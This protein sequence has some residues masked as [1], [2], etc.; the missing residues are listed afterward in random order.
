MLRLR[1]VE[2][3]AGRE[4]VELQ[5]TVDEMAAEKQRL[6]TQLSAINEDREALQ[7]QLREV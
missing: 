7:E 1:S 3:A 2:A 5:S 6:E 4:L